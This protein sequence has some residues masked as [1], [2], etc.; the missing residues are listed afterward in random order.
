MKAN[1]K[2]Q[3]D[4]QEES[5][6]GASE[7]QGE[8]VADEVVVLEDAEEAEVGGEAEDQDGFAAGP[9]RYAFEPK[10]ADVIDHGQGQ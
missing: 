2:G 8:V 6:A 9:G 5:V 4:I 1:A 7:R 10:A 3:D